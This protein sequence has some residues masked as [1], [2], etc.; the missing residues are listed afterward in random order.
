MTDK[1][2]FRFITLILIACQSSLVSCGNPNPNVSRKQLLELA[3][4][5][6]QKVDEKPPFV[7]PDTSYKP[8]I[9]A[10]YTEIR[11]VDPASPPVTLKVSVPQGA[12]QPLKLSMFGSS[13]EY[14]K[15]RLPGENDFFLSETQ[16]SMSWSSDRV[17]TQ[18]YRLGDHFVT[19]DVLGIRLFSPSGHFV[20]NLLM[21][22]FEGKRDVNKIEVD[23]ES[24][25]RATIQRISGTRCYL[26]FVDYEGNIKIFRHLHFN[27]VHIA[28]KTYDKD[29]KK[30]IWAGE[31][32]LEKRP[33]YSP[34]TELPDLTP[35]VE[36]VPVRSLL[37]GSIVDN[38]TLF[39]FLRAGDWDGMTF[40][41]MGDTLCKFTN[42]V[43]ESGGASASDRSFF[44]RADG[45]LFYRQEYSD[46]IFRVKSANQIVPAYRFDF[47]AQR[48]T[49][50]EG[51]ND[52]TKGKLIPFHWFVF[53]NSMLL[54]FSEG[55]DC[56]ACRTRNEVTFH[57]L[58][59]DKKTG[60]STAVDMRSQYPENILIENDIDDGMPLP[61]TSLRTQGDA[62]I[63]TFTKRQIEEIMKNK[64]GNISS[65]MISKIKTLADSLKFNEM[66]VIMIND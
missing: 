26:S 54:V 21:S 10:K 55:R 36:M 41:N 47:G 65:E 12:K 31:F 63:A 59:Y 5:T 29:A 13:V 57:C 17:N 2:I 43:V 33:I 23:F 60:Q 56:P 7:F 8:P 22:E 34:Q 27:F 32:D 62:L 30:K 66:L 19:S 24:F 48:L 52:R 64:A 42:Y 53:K 35:G 37:S 15:L 44:Y 11:S 18:V 1:I 61:L 9:G 6:A 49:A 46:T 50:F 4:D 51:R 38:N 20:Q 25:K 14:V 3:S 45:Q 16:V 40:N 58:L 28:D 39:N